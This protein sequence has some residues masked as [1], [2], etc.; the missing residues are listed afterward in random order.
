MKDLD[1]CWEALS[2]ADAVRAGD[3][4]AV[5]I[6]TPERSVPFLKERLRPVEAVDKK[7][8]AELIADLDAD[9]FEKREAASHALAQFGETAETALRQALQAKPSPEAK[10]RL[11]ELLDKLDSRT[12]S[13]ETLRAVRAVEA[14]EHIGTPEARQLLKALADGAPDARLTRDAKASLQRL[15][16]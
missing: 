10:R 8:V 6:G 7:Q 4:L 12:L 2:G 16:K 13:P 14:L 1:A 11:N 5:L 3:A 15:G 9:A